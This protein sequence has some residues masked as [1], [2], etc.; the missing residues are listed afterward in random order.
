M[1]RT[2]QLATI[3]QRYLTQSL[4]YDQVLNISCNLLNMVAVVQFLSRIWLLVAPCTAACPA[5]LILTIS[6]SL[7][8]LMS[9]E[10]VMLSKHLTLCHPL[11]LPLVFPSIRVFTNKSALHIR[12]PKYWNFSFSISP[13]S[14][15]SGLISFWVDWSPYCLRDSQESSLAPQFKS[16]N[17]SLLSL[18][19]GPTFIAVH[20][21]WENHLSPF[22]EKKTGP[23][24]ARNGQKR[25]GRA[26]RAGPGLPHLPRLTGPPQRQALAA[27]PHAGLFCLVS[28]PLRECFVHSRFSHMCVKW[29]KVKQQVIWE[30][31]RYFLSWKVSGQSTY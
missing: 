4:C 9:S 17:F 24:R 22:S 14:E 26:G 19:R 13:F 29:V 10:S 21:Y 28:C 7:F 30:F 1:L 6:W 5:P 25:H 12:C 18:L 20:D 11:L 3:G 23:R 15:Y 27:R 31:Q 8:K 16:I 2:F